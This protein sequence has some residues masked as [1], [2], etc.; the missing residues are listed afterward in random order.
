MNKLPLQS[1]SID[2]FR[3]HADRRMLSPHYL[4]LCTIHMQWESSVNIRGYNS[5]LLPSDVIAFAT[6]PGQR[7]LTG[8]SLI[9]ICHV[10][11]KEPMR[12]RAV[13]EKV[14][15]IQQKQTLQTNNARSQH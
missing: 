6:F 7:L 12:A 14:Q 10:T 2:D 3:K 11:S 5:A 9:V 15:A 8:N 1:D 4:Q 13:E